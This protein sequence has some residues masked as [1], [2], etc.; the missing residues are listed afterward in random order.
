[1]VISPTASG[2]NGREVKR[3]SLFDNVRGRGKKGGLPLLR[4][5]F[6]QNY[7]VTRG[8]R[9]GKTEG[10]KEPARREGKKK[11]NSSLFIQT[12]RRQG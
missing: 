4:I 1:M 12:S 9:E 3:E 8:R 10:R 6:L 5:A 11:E 7:R 2:Q